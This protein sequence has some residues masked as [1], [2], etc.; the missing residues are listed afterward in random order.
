MHLKG[1]SKCEK[2]FFRLFNPKPQTDFPRSHMFVN[3]ITIFQ[4]NNE[5]IQTLKEILPSAA[6]SGLKITLQQA[7]VSITRQLS[8][9]TLRISLEN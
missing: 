4:I 8:P 5:F 2:Q 9:V 1:I 3:I 6:R 7:S